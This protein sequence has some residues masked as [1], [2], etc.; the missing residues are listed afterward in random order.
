[1]RGQRKSEFSIDR[2]SEREGILRLMDESQ[3]LRRDRAAET[4]Q[5][6]NR[7]MV[8]RMSVSPLCRTVTLLRA[9]RPG[10]VR[11]RSQSSRR[12]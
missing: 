4:Q 9:G 10:G 12:V 8:R 5:C 6:R 3:P 2:G 11:E 7:Q 1:M